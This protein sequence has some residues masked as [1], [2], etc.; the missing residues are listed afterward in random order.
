[1]I[2]FYLDIMRRH[3]ETL[4]GYKGHF[5]STLKI[6]G[7]A[8]IQYVASYN[9]IFNLPALLIKETSKCDAVWLIVPH[10][11]YVSSARRDWSSSN[12]YVQ[13]T[14]TGSSLFLVLTVQP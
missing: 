4:C 2:A 1:M 5:I 7:F 6:T 12:G 10:D 8:P 3:Y 14:S 13:A 9:G 11:V